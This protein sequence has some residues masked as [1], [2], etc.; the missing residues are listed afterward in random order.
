VQLKHPDLRADDQRTA[1]DPDSI[2]DDLLANA[3]ALNL[4]RVGIVP[5]D[6]VYP[7][8]Y[9]VQHPLLAS[10]CAGVLGNGVDAVLPG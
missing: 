10:G 4:F 7:A 2:V 5:V 9:C 3:A 1:D 8:G 6:L